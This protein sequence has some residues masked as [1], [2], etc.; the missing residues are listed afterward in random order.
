MLS[1]QVNLRAITKNITAIKKRLQPNT[2]FCAVVK[3]NAYGFGL[4]RISHLIAPLVDCFAVMTI[5]EGIALRNYGI[6]QDILILGVT[7]DFASAIKHN[8]IVTLNTVTEAKYLRQ[9]HLRPRLHIAINTGM[10]RFGLN[11][12]HEL[13][14]VLQILPDARLEGCYTHLAYEAD[15]PAQIDQALVQFQKF[16]RIVKQYY[17]HAIL[18]AGCSGVINYPTAHLDMLRIGKAMYGGT[19]DT[20]TA[21]TI[22]SQ[23]I[24]VKKIKAGATVGYNGEFVAPKAM[25]IGVVQGGY[26]HGIQRQLSGTASVIVNNHR[27]PIVGRICMDCFFIDVT[28]LNRP[29][30][31]TVTIMTTGHGQT[32]MD[33]AKI[34]QTIP[35]YL[36]QG[37]RY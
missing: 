3:S 26:A 11:S 14:A 2:K 10:N 7:T 13:R 9:N 15:H 28:D 1:V 24:A 20:Q 4:E 25:Q 37:F 36:L 6:K 33:L 32:L 17:P 35:C 23:I 19:P 18:H 5:V 16:T 12:V 34:T 21:L 31:Q 27:C 29:L 22:K 8:L 30:G